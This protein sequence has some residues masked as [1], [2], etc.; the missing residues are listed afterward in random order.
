[1]IEC[2]TMST[3]FN[4]NA[5]IIDQQHQLRYQ[6]VVE[7]LE[8]TNIYVSNNR[9]Y[10]RYDTY[11]SEYLIKR[12][13]DG[14]ILG[15]IRTSPTT[16]PYMLKEVF[17]DTSDIAL[18][19]SPKHHEL[20]RMVVNRYILNSEQS[21]QVR[22][23]LLLAAIERGVQRGISAYWGIVVKAVGEKVFKDTGYDVEYLGEPATYPNTGEKIY[24]VKLPVSQEVY[25]RVQEATG[26]HTS[27]LSFGKANEHKHDSPMLSQDHLEQKRPGFKKR[28]EGMSNG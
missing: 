6:E 1:M 22:R 24:G 18:P 12:N 8:W 19:T 15:S 2:V 28:L 16:T 4:F 20:S 5:H 27:I 23:E 7:G 9:E 13:K 17:S 25:R 10:D 3:I 11:D 21:K 26:I 14:V